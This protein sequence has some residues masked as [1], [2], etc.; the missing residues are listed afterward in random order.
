MPFES[1]AG[2]A[3]YPVA[4]WATFYTF[5]FGWSFRD[6]QISQGGGVGAAGRHAIHFNVPLGNF[7]FNNTIE[8]MQIAQ[9]AGGRS[10]KLT[11]DP[12]TTSGG[13]SYSQILDSSLESIDLDT[14]GDGITIA[15]NFIGAGGSNVPLRMSFVTGAGGF[16]CE[17]NVL[18][19]A[20]VILNLVNGNGIN[21]AFN[22]IETTGASAG[23]IIDVNSS[24][25]AMLA[26]QLTR[27]QISVLTGTAIPVRV[28]TGTANARLADM[29]YLVPAAQTH[30]QIDTGAT[31]TSVDRNTQFVTGGVVGP[32]VI[33]NSGTRTCYVQYLADG[34]A[35]TPALSF[36]SDPATG[37]FRPGANA[38]GV[39][40]Q[41]N[42]VA[43]VS[44]TD[45]LSVQPGFALTLY[46]SSSGK[47]VLAPAAA[48]G[49]PVITVPSTSGT[50]AIA[51]RGTFTPAVA[52]GGASVGITYSGQ[53]CVYTQIDNVLTF[54][55]SI[56]LTSKGSSTGSATITGLPVTVNGNMAVNLAGNQFAASAATALQAT[57]VNAS[58]TVNL[59]KFSAG[60]QT[61]L[62]DTDFNNNTII[63]LAGAYFV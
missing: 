10:I 57:V 22:Y 50:I 32:L 41:G 30:L 14:A 63:R 37:I 29:R 39:A 11:N 60:A 2:R 1:V 4:H 43:R 36:L 58:T 16:L 20:G 54:A 52:F 53:T 61:A 17:D 46:G 34:V 47:A 9:T 55:I 25:G 45:G 3:F 24:G 28:R 8:R 42:E 31:D 44:T 21:V 12:A 23:A 26:P 27:N 51:N 35:A 13:F 15:G 38:I 62:A 19:G 56:T 48:A 33:A 40:A 49:T 6:F 18:T 59:F 7:A 5:T